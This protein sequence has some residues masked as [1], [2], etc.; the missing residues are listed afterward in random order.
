MYLRDY[1]LSALSLQAQRLNRARRSPLLVQV[2][3]IEITELTDTSYLPETL[4]DV[5]ALDD[6]KVT[7]LHLYHRNSWLLRVLE[8][9]NSLH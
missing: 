8:P 2:Q 1:A 3:C 9:S 7:T 4:K 6:F 5:M